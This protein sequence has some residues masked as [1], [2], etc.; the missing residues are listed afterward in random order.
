MSPSFP[1]LLKSCICHTLILMI[2]EFHFSHAQF[3]TLKSIHLFFNMTIKIFNS[4]IQF[5]CIF[6]SPF[7]NQFVIKFI[8]LYIWLSTLWCIDTYH[9]YNFLSKYM[10]HGHHSITPLYLNKLS[11]SSSLI[12]I[13]TLFPGS[14]L[15]TIT[16]IFFLQL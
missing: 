6:H 4:Q 10:A 5:F 9:S 3:Y 13:P 11:H 8:L 1:L 14:F 7:M 2:T 15:T 16:C 12:N